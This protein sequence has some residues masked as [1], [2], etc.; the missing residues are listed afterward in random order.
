M[1]KNYFK[2]CESKTR[3]SRMKRIDLKS[4]IGTGQVSIPK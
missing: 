3:P 2:S 1:P 4:A